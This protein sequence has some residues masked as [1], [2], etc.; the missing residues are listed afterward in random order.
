MYG[1]KL[2]AEPGMH[3]ANVASQFEKIELLEILKILIDLPKDVIELMDLQYMIRVQPGNR[4]ESENTPLDVTIR[5]QPPREEQA[6][7]P[8]YMK[9]DTRYVAA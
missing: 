6:K 8:C 5:A 4:L 3:L 2:E 9:W 7:E 1:I